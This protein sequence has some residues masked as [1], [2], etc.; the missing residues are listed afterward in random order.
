MPHQCVR[1]GTFYN[2]GSDAIL[3]GCECGAKLFFYVRKEQIE[4][5]KESTES[6][7]EIQKIQIETD[8]RDILGQTDINEPVILD[9][10]SVKIAAP[11]RYEIDLVHL[12][13]G[14]PLVIKIEDGK[15]F[16][17]V[18]N[19]FRSRK[20]GKQTQPSIGKDSERF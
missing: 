16:I 13:R 2:D 8:V 5:A 4:K 14:D 6:L 15:Y 19:T 11:G 3:K 20:D 12:F 18:A 9:F 7:S 1:C 10:E 17:D